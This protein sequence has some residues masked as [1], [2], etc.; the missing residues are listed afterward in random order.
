M[1]SQGLRALLCVGALLGLWLFFHRAGSP[2]GGHPSE[3]TVQ[4]TQEPVATL[5]GPEPSPAAGLS[6]P[7]QSKAPGM[8]E[9]TFSKL[10]GEILKAL[11]TLQ[12][13]RELSPEEV[14]R[15]P[16]LILEAGMELGKIARALEENP[17]LSRSA[18]EFYKQCAERAD[19]PRSV[20]ALCLSNAKPLA[21]R[22]EG[23][24]SV[25]VPKS[26]EELADRARSN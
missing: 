23:I 20:R 2:I 18:F 16:D 8:S 3:R 15:T 6:G 1:R 24:G 22:L 19:L 25:S 14:H 12:M 13:L 21:S 5:N 7:T 9:A 26:V 17:A 4:R 10:S 11:P